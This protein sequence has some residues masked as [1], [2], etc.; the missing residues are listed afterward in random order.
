MT[1][2]A[3]TTKQLAKKDIKALVVGDTL[4]KAYAWLLVQRKNHSHN[5]SIWHLR[6]HW[7]AIKPALQKSLLLGEYR[8]NP[9]I[10]HRING[11]CIKKGFDFLGVRFSETPE[12]S[13][14]TVENHQTR[15]AR[16]YALNKS[17]ALIIRYRARWKAWCTGLLKCC[18]ESSNNLSSLNGLRASISRGTLKDEHYENLHE[19]LET[20]Y[21]G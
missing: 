13:K 3:Q 1:S 14:T 2:I 8:I 18:M 12:I 9:V 7:D 10:S 20:S 11:E 15:L 17:P 6:H 21:I 16:R 4:E 19:N 5:N